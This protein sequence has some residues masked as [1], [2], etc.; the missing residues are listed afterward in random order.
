M[1]STAEAN[2]RQNG[3]RHESDVP[4]RNQRFFIGLARAF[5]GSLIF[6]L[7]MLMT[8]E[9]WWIGFYIDPWKLIL[10]LI[11]QVPLLIGLARFGGFQHTACLRDDVVDAF[12]AIAVALV[13]AASVLYL[14]KVLTPDMPPSEIIGKIALQAFPGSFGAILARAQTGD[15][16]V[17]ESDTDPSYPAELLL[18]AA[19]ALFLGLNVAPTEEMIL[20]SYMMEP[21]REIALALVSLLLMHAF[22]YSVD[23]PGE[24]QPRSWAEVEI[25]RAHV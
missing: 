6:A 20:I 24:A 8:M 11:I 14:F 25:G 9:M 5:A 23:F 3:E 22:V 19:G 1:S 18:M 12:V 2:R 10:L 4:V 15:K 16:T 17:G 7:P 13:M 21:W